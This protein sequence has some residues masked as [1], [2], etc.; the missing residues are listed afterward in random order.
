MI[1]SGEI[2]CNDRIEAG[3]PRLGSLATNSTLIIYFPK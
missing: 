3:L 2:N 1:Y